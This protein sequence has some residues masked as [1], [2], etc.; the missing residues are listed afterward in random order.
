MWP[1]DAVGAVWLCA[2]PG[3]IASAAIPASMLR[4]ETR[5]IDASNLIFKSSTPCSIA[6]R[7]GEQPSHGQDAVVPHADQFVSMKAQSA[8]A[9]K[10][11][12]DTPKCFL[13]L[14]EKT[15]WLA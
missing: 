3:T 5:A 7:R 2:T 6:P 13:K 15:E 12:G 8:L 10:S 1:G 4:R 14:C 11:R 9:W